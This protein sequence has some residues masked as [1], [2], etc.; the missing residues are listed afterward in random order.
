MQVQV[1]Y[2]NL[3]HT[4]LCLK[5]QVQDSMPYVKNYI[6][7][8]IETPRQLFYYLRSQTQ[9]KKDPK[10]TELL[11]MVPTL[12]DRGGK[13][14]CDCFTI[15]ALAC[16][17]YLN[18][19]PHYVALVGNNSFTPS[20]IYTEVYDPQKKR[21]WLSILLILVMVRNEITNINNV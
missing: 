15:L 3:T 17:H 14:D 19:L 16:Q 12:M 18:F 9:Y 11:Q 8:Y 6:P 4:L 7:D 21:L 10:G 13:G 20:H 5:I 1:P 2:Q